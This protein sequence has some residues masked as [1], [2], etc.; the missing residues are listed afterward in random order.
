MG[1]DKRMMGVQGERDSIILGAIELAGGGNLNKI[2][3][4]IK[5]FYFSADVQNEIKSFDTAIDHSIAEVLPRGFL[6]NHK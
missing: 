3:Q 2:D 4:F 6:L 5:L 1:W